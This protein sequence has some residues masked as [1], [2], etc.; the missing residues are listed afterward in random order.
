MLLTSQILDQPICFD[1]LSGKHSAQCP[2][3]NF[4]NFAP[5]T[6]RCFMSQ[7]YNFPGIGRISFAA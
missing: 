1:K 6:M 3:P 4:S 7:N 2:A 5:G